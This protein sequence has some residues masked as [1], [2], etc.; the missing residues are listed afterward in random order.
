MEIN[1]LL[2]ATYKRIT[3]IPLHANIHMYVCMIAVRKTKIN[4]YTYGIFTCDYNEKH[5]YV[6]ISY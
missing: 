6:F 2:N 1:L 3:T 4:I 5:T